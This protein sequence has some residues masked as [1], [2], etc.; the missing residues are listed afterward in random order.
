M[1]GS[2][3]AAMPTALAG[4]WLPAEFG[5]MAAAAAAAFL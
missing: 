3:G 2:E 1:T 5:V 4:Q